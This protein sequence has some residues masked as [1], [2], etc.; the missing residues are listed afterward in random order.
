MDDDDDDSSASWTGSSG[1][2]EW[3]KTAKNKE[4]EV[5]EGTKEGLEKPNNDP[6]LQSGLLCRFYALRSGMRTVSRM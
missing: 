5:R 6:F 3:L 4:R 2:L 1:F